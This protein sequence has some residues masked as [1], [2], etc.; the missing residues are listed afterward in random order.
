VPKRRGFLA[1]ALLLIFSAA[2]LVPSAAAEST[3]DAMSAFGLIGTWSADCA[4][5][6][7][8]GVVRLT[9]SLPLIGSP[10]IIATVGFPAVGVTTSEFEIR[11]AVRVTEEKIKYTSV[12][13]S[14]SN[15]NTK[16]TTEIDDRPRETVLMKNG[17][18]IRVS[19]S[20]TAD[21]SEIFVQDGLWKEQVQ[22]RAP[23][24]S[25]LEKCLN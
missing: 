25:L 6:P 24:T 20:R 12:R 16:L 5:G 9:Y 7:L 22:G 4:K 1:A 10:K 19:D 15:A 8:S 21:G 11:S 3:G 23:A 17:G 14:S 18:K 13:V 2:P